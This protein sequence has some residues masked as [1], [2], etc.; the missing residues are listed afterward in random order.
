MMNKLFGIL[1]LLLAPFPL[2]SQTF[3]I[4]NSS[5]SQ[6]EVRVGDGPWR[7]LRR[8]DKDA[9]QLQGS[10][11][12]RVVKGTVS[13][14]LESDNRT[15]QIAYT[16]TWSVEQVWQG[17]AI[18]EQ[19]NSGRMGGIEKGELP[20]FSIDVCTTEGLVGNAFKIGDYLSSVVLTNHSDSALYALIVWLEED[21][22]GLFRIPRFGFESRLI[23]PHRLSQFFFPEPLEIQA[24]PGTA[25]ICVCY[26]THP[27][28][29][30]FV[31]ADITR[32]VDFARLMSSYGISTVGRTVSFDY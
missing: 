17:K 18:P 16:G 4:N 30:P 1:L 27:F 12:I 21:A 14:R 32:A 26:A 9:L 19:P 31:P 6:N 7:V 13:V 11:S 23:D 10:D 2:L 8:A 20:P 5:G 3:V 15:S 22:G 29:Y 28:E 25:T 24:P